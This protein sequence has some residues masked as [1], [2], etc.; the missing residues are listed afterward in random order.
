MEKPVGRIDPLAIGMAPQT[1][2]GS[3]ILVRNG[4][5][6][7]NLPLPDVHLEITGA[8]TMAVAHR[9]DNFVFAFD[10]FF[11]HLV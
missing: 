9:M 5:N 1:H 6:S 8:S 4:L 7:N 11:F 2:A 10:R 3:P